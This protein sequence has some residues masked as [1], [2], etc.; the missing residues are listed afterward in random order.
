MSSKRIPLEELDFLH[1]ISTLRSQ[2]PG[3]REDSHPVG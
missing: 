2:H 1:K 3:L